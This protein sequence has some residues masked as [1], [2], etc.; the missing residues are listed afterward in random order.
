[1]M[2]YG[3]NI[4]EY[5]MSRLAAAV[6][7]SFPNRLSR[8]DSLFAYLSKNEENITDVVSLGKITNLSF[9]FLL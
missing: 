6:L 7:K 5:R 9:L 2:A 8:L 4:S 3:V 1:M